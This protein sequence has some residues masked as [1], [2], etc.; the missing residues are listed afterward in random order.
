MSGRQACQGQVLQPWGSQEVG[1]QK[2][3][4]PPCR[5]SVW[6]MALTRTA[7]R[8]V[9]SSPAFW[10]KLTFKVGFKDSA[11][12]SG[13]VGSIPGSGQSPGEGNGD[14][15]QYSCLE[16]AKDRGAWRAT[17][18]GVAESDAT[19]QLSICV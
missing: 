14:L 1:M 7:L 4:F 12:Q 11:C 16:N 10:L 5:Q 13:D 6:S 18:Y 9:V 17:V 2:N 15:L 3:V 8:F 19:E